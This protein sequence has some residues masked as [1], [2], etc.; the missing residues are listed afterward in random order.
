MAYVGGLFV[1]A[2]QVVNETDLFESL[3]GAS[4]CQGFI[5]GDDDDAC[6]CSHCGVVAGVVVD[7]CKPFAYY[8]ACENGCGENDSY[9][10]L[11]CF[12]SHNF[13]VL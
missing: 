1:V 8:K 10:N 6:E 12:F 11:F 13:C 9:D 7:G 5:F 2:H 3:F 4:F